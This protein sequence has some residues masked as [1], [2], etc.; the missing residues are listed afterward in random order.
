MPPYNRILFVSQNYIRPAMKFRLII[1]ALCFGL[2]ALAWPSQAQHSRPQQSQG[3][4][5]IRVDTDLV[6]IDIAA[7]DKAGNYVRDLRAEDFQ[8][9]EDGR[10]RKIDFF[11]VTDE[12]TLSRPLAVVFALDLSGSL[13][14]EETVTLR[15]AAMRLTELMKGDSVFAALAF[16]YDV[17]VLQDFTPDPQKI[18]RAFAKADHFEGSTRIYDAIDRAVTMLARRA[19]RSHH[20]RPLR[21]IVIVITDG[22]DSASVIDRRELIRRTQ[23]ASVTVY[24]VTLPS[25]M[26]SATSAH[27]RVITPL[28]A[29]RV[30]AATGGRDFAADARDFTPI[31]KALAEEIRASYALAYYPDIRDGKYHE[32]WVLTSRPGVELRPSRTGYTAPVK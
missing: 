11:S 28:D 20:G 30:V 14:P 15:R 23:A 1:T 13:K 16:N 26:L 22:F 6:V 25:Y 2:V 5:T 18:E 7:T 3:T 31:F 32:L 8:V 21:R 17:K 10:P 29:S 19:P 27:E 12:A 4:N 9:F 24:S